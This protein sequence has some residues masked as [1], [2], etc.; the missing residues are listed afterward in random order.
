MQVLLKHVGTQGDVQMSEMNIVLL[1]KTGSGKSASGNTILGRDVFKKGSFSKSTTKL[2]EKHTQTVEDTHITVIDT[3]GLFHTSMTDEELMAETGKCLEMSAPGPHVFLLVIR[4][5]VRFTEE[6]RETLKWIQKN[7]GED[8]MRF[9]LILFNGV[10]QLDKPIEEFL[11]ENTELKEVLS[12]YGA[13]YH[14]ITNVEKNDRSQVSELMKK[15]KDLITENGG[16]CY[17]QEMYQE[18]QRKIREEEEARLKREEEED[19][20]NREEKNRKRII[21]RRVG[22]GILIGGLFCFYLYRYG[23]IYQS[24]NWLMFLFGA[25]SSE[26]IRLFVKFGATE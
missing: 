4:L 21:L 15:I 5:D 11:L 22:V 8:V 14:A 17:T 6:E 18:T 9:I 2:C 25:H 19:R 13:R 7:F 16:Q 3:P 20:L 26:P 1:G 12:E 24:Y 10:D 23:R